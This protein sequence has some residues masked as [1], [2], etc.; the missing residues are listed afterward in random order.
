MS[1]LMDDETYRQKLI[2][3][4]VSPRH[5]DERL[6]GRDLDRMGNIVGVYR[7]TMADQD[8]SRFAIETFAKRLRDQRAS[9]P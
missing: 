6:D 7:T 2:A 3:N 4:G 1:V 9:R 5:L 8:P